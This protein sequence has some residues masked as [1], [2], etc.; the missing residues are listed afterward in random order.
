MGAGARLT[1]SEAESKALVARY[2]IPVPAE[3]TVPDAVGAVL[4]ATEIG[5]PVVLKA[6]SPDIAH[7]SD[8]GAVR[9]GL[10]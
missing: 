9:L 10:S 2:G 7:K 6:R 3:R 4:A 1:L 5:F 8:V